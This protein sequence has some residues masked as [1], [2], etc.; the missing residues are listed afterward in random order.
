MKTV[1]FGPWVGE[2][3]WEFMHWHGW[4]RKVSRTHFKDYRRIVSSFAGREPFYPDTTEYWAHPPEYASKFVSARNYITD[5]WIEGMPRPNTRFSGILGMLGRH[6]KHGEQSQH[7]DVL[8]QA[9]ALLDRYRAELPEDTEFFV[10]YTLCSFP[11]DDLKFGCDIRNG[12]RRDKD[13]VAIKLP[14]EKQLFEHLRPGAR[15][16][17]IFW[18]LYRDDK[19]LVCIFARY[20][21]LRRPDKNWTE[22]KYLGLL[23]DIRSEFPQY[24]IAFVGEPN[25]TYFADQVPEGCVDLINIDPAH[26][27]DIQVAALQMSMLSIGG[28]SG[29]L[30]VALASGSP[31]LTWSWKTDQQRFYGENLMKSP[32]YYYPEVNP[33][34]E[35][36]MGCVRNMMTDYGSARQSEIVRHISAAAE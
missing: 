33:S 24:N 18:E 14:F 2:F 23:A 30:L 36:V 10:P 17:E 31:A 20:R 7:L 1:F 21:A 11:P 26:R 28:L 16:Q 13:F 19:P 35:E 6:R 22:E 32:V 27:M 3:G 25:G 4:I 34:V 12:G 8:P 15:G 5:Y 9:E 29:A